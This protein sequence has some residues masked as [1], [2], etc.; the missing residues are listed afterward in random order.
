MKGLIG[1][2]LRLSPVKKILMTDTLR[3]KFLESMKKGAARD[4][5]GWLTEL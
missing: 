5:K 4:G 1:G 2:F 3:S